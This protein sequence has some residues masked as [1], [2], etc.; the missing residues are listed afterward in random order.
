MLIRHY[1][2]LHKFLTPF[3]VLAMMGYYDNWTV[4]PFVYLAL[5]GTYGFLWLIKEA[6]FR[7]ASFEKP[8]HPVMGW[9]T[10]FGLLASYWVAPWILIS[11]AKTPP[12]WLIG[13][14][15]SI[16]IFGVFF[17]F[18]S[19]AYKHATLSLKKGL[20]TE[21]LFARCRN[22][23]YLGEMLIYGG[24]ALLAMSWIPF[25]IL[26][27][28]WSLFVVNAVKKDKSIS[29]HPG[30]DAW[31]QRSWLLFPNP[32]AA[33]PKGDAGSVAEPASGASG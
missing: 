5:H 7:D 4:G 14:A 22:P 8:I 3:A 10:L 29:R 1:I 12:P 11:A 24:F 26:A 27:F 28:W 2:N 30:F 23:N 25:A 15:V 13:L 20:I 21:Q 33:K 6:T 18:A 32:F 31:K 17:H 16:N 19:D 9:I